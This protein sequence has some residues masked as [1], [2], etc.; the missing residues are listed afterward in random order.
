MNP[1]KKKYTEE[2]LRIKQLSAI[3]KVL[4]KGDVEN[5]FLTNTDKDVESVKDT[6]AERMIEELNLGKNETRELQLLDSLISEETETETR[7]A[8]R[9]SRPAKVQ[10]VRAR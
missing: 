6:A 10:P 9:A 7:R 2:I 8:A 1:K 3:N 5:A 4:K